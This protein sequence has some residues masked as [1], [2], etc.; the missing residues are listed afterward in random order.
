[1]R[2]D[3][4][5]VWFD[6]MVPEPH[7]FQQQNAYLHAFFR[8]NLS[9]VDP[10]GWGLMQC[11]IDS[12]SLAKGKFT[13][14]RCK[15]ILPDGFVFE[16]PDQYPL[17][18]S[19]SF[20]DS[21]PANQESVS[22]YLSLAEQRAEGNNCLIPPTSSN[23]ETRFKYQEISVMD[24]NLG[25][26]E[27]TIGVASANFQLKFG[28]ENLH[29]LTCIKIAEVK[30][31]PAGSF[32]LNE[33]YFPP[34]ITVASSAEIT[35]IVQAV[36]ERLT[37]I[38]SFLL[39]RRKLRSTG[40]VEYTQYDVSILW[41]LYIVN[42]YSPLLHHYLT[43]QQH[44]I[45]VYAALLMLAGQLSS[46]SKETESLQTRLPAYEH[47]A[48][49]PCFLAL[50]ALIR[51]LMDEAVPSAEYVSIPLEKRHESVYQVH[52]ADH[53]LLESSRLFLICSS[54]TIS[55]AKISGEVPIKIKIASPDAIQ[56]VLRRFLP[57]LKITR[58]T[59]PPAGLPS[60]LQAE[61]FLLEKSGPYWE[62]ILKVK[63]LMIFIPTDL[64]GLKLEMV[65]LR[66]K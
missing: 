45:T 17:P 7:H 39:D 6:G 36:V 44:P 29:G 64:S 35:A 3:V 46:F 11:E 5:V 38:R 18:N 43:T 66:D 63:T 58:I 2:R 50:A 9:A 8:S 28:D 33:N 57:A 15:G 14:L 27:R 31:T 62:S 42:T 24:D 26:E 20:I 23:R 49:G 47:N 1:M 12:E 52:F 51:K 19:R 13:L 53:T 54:T 32:V 40:Q 25:G 55:Q 65:A 22:V 61:Y 34:S 60:R 30:R 37:G 41:L 21:F 59:Q 16:L 56:D 4:N 48:L 10:Y